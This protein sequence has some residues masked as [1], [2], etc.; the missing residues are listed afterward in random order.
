MDGDSLVWD[1]Q[2]LTLH[3]TEVLLGNIDAV[4][5]PVVSRGACPGV[6]VA[7]S[8]V[9]FLG[10]YD[11]EKSCT[12]PFLFDGVTYLADL[13][14]QSFGNGK[15]CTP[16]SMAPGDEVYLA[17]RFIE[18]DGRSYT[19]VPFLVEDGQVI[20]PCCPAPSDP[21]QLEAA[22]TSSQEADGAGL[23]EGGED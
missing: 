12:I 1:E 16:W 7:T 11:G 9:L 15:F 14:D 5:A 8:N 10:T 23:G 17:V 19:M 2:V 6:L 3:G 4:H 21:Q 13:G 20:S 18:E 22:L